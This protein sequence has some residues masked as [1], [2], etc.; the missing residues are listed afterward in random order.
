M[1]SYP[2]SPNPQSPYNPFMWSKID[3]RTVN[4]FGSGCYPLFNGQHYCK[5]Y[6][7]DT[8]IAT[9]TSCGVGMPI[10]RRVRNLGISPIEYVWNGTK[11]EPS[12]DQF[13]TKDL[14][15]DLGNPI[16][17]TSSFDGYA[18]DSALVAAALQMEMYDSLGHDA[19]AIALFHEVLTSPLDR[20]NMDVRWRMEWGRY[21]M[22]S[23]LENMFMQDELNAANN[24][25]TFEVP[26]QQY[27]DVLNAMTD[28]L[29]TDST[30]KDQFYIEID[31][32]QLFR[33]LGNPMM[34]RHIYQHLDDCQLDSLEQSVLNN[35]R[36]E[37]D[38]ELSLINQYLE[39]GIAPDSIS[40]A[41]DTTNYTPAIAYE[42]SNYY[43]GVWI[44]GPQS[45]TFVSCGA[46][47]TYKMRQEA[48]MMLSI[49]P[50]PSNGGVYLQTN[51]VG[52]LKIQVLDMSGRVCRSTSMASDGSP[53]WCP[54]TESLPNGS[55]YISLTGPEGVQVAPICI[56]K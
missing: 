36:Q 5:I 41:V 37:V 13:V 39:E 45:A 53:M 20:T 43:F 14:E 18:L 38:I 29:L 25:Q 22:K 24:V 12:K 35:W 6:L 54:I 3:L 49:Y 32:G 21:H 16:I 56:V 46:D 19:T 30:Y 4:S 15:I 2:P 26:V 55:Y 51:A 27:V 23:A 47:A 9:T 44:D 42:A 7:T 50:N 17:Y 8:E 34:A 31:K 1:N 48:K 40:F 52:I 11:P 10:V 33:T 28:T